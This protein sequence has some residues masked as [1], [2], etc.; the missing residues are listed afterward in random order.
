MQ[1]SSECH[2][3]LET[4]RTATGIS[5]P[6]WRKRQPPT[7]SH[8]GRSTASEIAVL[9][10]SSGPVVSACRPCRRTT[11]GT[12]LTQRRRV[13]MTRQMPLV[14]SGSAG[15]GCG[16]RPQLCHVARRAFPEAQTRRGAAAEA[17]TGTE[18]TKTVPAAA[19]RDGANRPL[20]D[21]QP[22]GGQRNRDG[23]GPFNDSGDRWC[24]GPVQPHRG[25]GADDAHRGSDRLLLV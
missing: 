12:E 6:T 16:G 10:R 18:T 24:R 13:P 25:P 15:T 11:P 14:R 22:P 1:V 21:H 5:N 9:D 17:S 23:A 20:T 7:S 8:R 2:P 4:V 19:C 3:V